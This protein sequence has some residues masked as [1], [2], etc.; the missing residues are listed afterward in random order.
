[1]Q[2]SLLLL[3]HEDQLQ[4]VEDYVI[5]KEGSFGKKEKEEKKGGRGGE[6][7]GERGGGF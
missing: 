1:M 4:H 6:C 5:F 7:T 3:S 2:I